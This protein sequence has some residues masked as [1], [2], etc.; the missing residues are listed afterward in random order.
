MRTRAFLFSAIAVSL[1]VAGA[2]AA[3]DIQTIIT[4][5]INNTAKITS[6]SAAFTLQE[7]TTGMGGTGATSCVPRNIT[8]EF[9]RPDTVIFSVQKDTGWIHHNSILGGNGEEFPKYQ[10]IVMLNLLADTFPNSWINVDIPTFTALVDSEYADSIVIKH[11]NSSVAFSY[12]VD[13]KRWLV[14][15][16]VAGGYDVYDVNYTWG[17]TAGGIYYPSA[18]TINDQSNLCKGQSVF[19]NV[20]VNGVAVSSAAVPQNGKDGCGCGSGTGLAFI[21]PIGFKI[22]S[23]W[24]RKKKRTGA[25]KQI[26]K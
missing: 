22:G 3:T 26:V 8:W 14:T 5:I 24:K 16:V 6:Y 18:I 25:S 17:K 2:Q 10:A 21:P 7:D 1:C 20:K 23:W 13:K 12:T 11:M 4:N 9:S 19:T 15:R